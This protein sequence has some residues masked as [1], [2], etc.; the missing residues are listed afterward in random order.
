MI[1]FADSFGNSPTWFSPVDHSLSMQ[2]T[3]QMGEHPMTRFSRNIKTHPLFIAEKERYIS[4]YRDREK[5][6]IRERE[7]ER[8]REFWLMS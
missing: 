5:E 7:R 4:I 6:K 3:G 1:S 8:A 2:A